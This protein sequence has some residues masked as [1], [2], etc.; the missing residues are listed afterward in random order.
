MCRE[1]AK[2]WHPDFTISHAWQWE[3][4]VSMGSTKQLVGPLSHCCAQTPAA[5]QRTFSCKGQ[6]C[7]SSQRGRHCSRSADLAGHPASMVEQRNAGR[8]WGWFSVLKALRQWLPSSIR[9]SLTS[10][11]RPP[12]GDQVSECIDLWSCFI[13]KASVVD[14]W[15]GS[16]AWREN[17]TQSGWDLSNGKIHFKG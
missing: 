11:E 2:T 15:I 4:Q 1:P 9:T 12:T 14:F 5:T 13:L 17:D 10:K 3:Y 6:G 8:K 16:K 7:S